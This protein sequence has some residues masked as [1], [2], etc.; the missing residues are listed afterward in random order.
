MVK[1]WYSSHFIV[2]IFV[3][4]QVNESIYIKINSRTIK[5]SDNFETV[6]SK[7]EFT[8]KPKHFKD[9]KM[10]LKCQ[11]SQFNLYSG[12]SEIELEDDTPQLAH[13]LSPS[14]TLSNGEYLHL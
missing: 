7:L 9:G 1:V 3:F 2:V 11:A 13:V 10:R 12:S 5:D 6:K 4:L 14:S 8:A